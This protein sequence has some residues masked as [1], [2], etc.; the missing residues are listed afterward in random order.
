MH[1]A[2]YVYG[3]T[4][5]WTLLIPEGKFVCYSTKTHHCKKQ[6]KQYVT[7]LVKEKKIPKAFSNMTFVV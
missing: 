7:P 4:D 1:D 5:G 6:H 3:W 2:L